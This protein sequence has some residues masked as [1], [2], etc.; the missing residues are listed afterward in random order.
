MAMVG[1]SSPF[2]KPSVLFQ[3][4]ESARGFDA[5]IPRWKDGKTEPLLSVYS[6]KAF[7]R[8]SS[9]IKRKTLP[10]L[11]SNLYGVSYV[12][13]E[14]FILPLDPELHSFFRVRGDGDL[15]KARAIA[16]SR[17]E[18]PKRRGR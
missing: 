6:R 13:I 18:K 5:A 15:R 10:G 16:S 2:L 17:K 14:E 12:G 3:L 8:A 1:A 4:F 9:G 11:V 7:L